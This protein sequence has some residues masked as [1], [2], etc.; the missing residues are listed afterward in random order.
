MYNWDPSKFPHH[1]T[2]SRRFPA[3]YWDEKKNQVAFVESM[4]KK[5]NVTTKEGWYKVT[6][7]QFTACGGGRLLFKHGGSM[8]R[9]LSYVYS[10]YQRN[11][12]DKLL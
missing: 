10:E 9:M 7:H 4:A 6:A 2:T 3:H 12:T 5:L 8:I 11:N 1:V